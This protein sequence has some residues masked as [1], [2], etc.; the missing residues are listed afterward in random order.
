MCL[1]PQLAKLKLTDIRRKWKRGIKK[2]K[3]R[4][5]DVYDILNKISV[6][7]FTT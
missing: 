2:K 4:G 1:F 5:P 3:E 7:D 6:A